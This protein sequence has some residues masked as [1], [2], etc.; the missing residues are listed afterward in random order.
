MIRNGQNVVT[1]LVQIWAHKGRSVLT[2]L[3]VIIAVTA[4]ISVVSFVEGFGNYVTGMLQGYGTQ[5]I[6]VRPDIPWGWR[7]TGMRRVTMNMADVEAVRAECQN[8][9]RISPFIYGQEEVSYGGEVAKDIPIR[10]VSEQYQTIRN[11]F[12]DEGRFF[13]PVDADNGAYVCVLGR[14][15]LKQ[16]ECDESVVGDC[17]YIGERRF[18]VI[19]VLESKGSFMGDDQDETIMIPYSTALNM[20]PD[21]RDL[22]M[23]LAEATSESDIDQAEAQMIRVLRRRHGLQPGQPNDFQTE[24]QDQM[25]NELQRVRMIATSILAGIVSISLLV[26]GIGIMNVMLVSVSERTREIGLRK[27]VGGRRRDIMLQFLTEA[28]VLSTL[29]G[30]IGIVLGYV[31]SHIASMHPKMIEI[32]VPLWA[33]ALALGFSAGAGI[34][35]GVIPAFKAA[36]IHPIDALR[37]E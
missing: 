28:I 33:V 36:V 5:Y 21:R 22:V 7:Q 3:G 14:S 6:V 11:F 29:G 25:L 26:G 17:V 13:G 19:G 37:H 32:S 30:G 1:A 24:R 31:I 16:L 15:L 2:T 12:T 4:I 35:F 27:S 20:Y 9:H 8:I 10:G 34:V 18:R 23:F